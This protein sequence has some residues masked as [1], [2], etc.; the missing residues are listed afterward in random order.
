M[1]FDTGIAGA[2]TGYQLAAAAG[3]VAWTAASAIAEAASKNAGAA[4]EVVHI[5][6]LTSASLDLT[7]AYGSA[8]TQWSGKEA[9]ADSAAKHAV[10]DAAKQR[11]NAGAAAAKEWAKALSGAALDWSDAVWPGW[12]AY[13]DVQAHT[14][15]DGADKVAHAYADYQK[16]LATNNVTYVQ[17]LDECDLGSMCCQ[18]A[19]G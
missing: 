2:N 17:V 10:A 16:S 15:A 9:G 14:F 13:V 19:T 7:R 3:Q 6:S 4:I 12:A 5:A 8:A 18:A 11:A 1:A